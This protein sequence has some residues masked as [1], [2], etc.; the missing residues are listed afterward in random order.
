VQAEFGLLLE[1]LSVFGISVCFVG[2]SGK[3]N[4]YSGCE[5]LVK[6]AR[7]AEFAISAQQ[8][9]QSSHTPRRGNSKSHD[10]CPPITCSEV[11]PWLQPWSTAITQTTNKTIAATASDLIRMCAPP[12]HEAPV[13]C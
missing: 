5:N 2:L 7:D 8:Q 3:T 11:L 10:E 4:R 1:M 12:L 6:A 9:S 13:V